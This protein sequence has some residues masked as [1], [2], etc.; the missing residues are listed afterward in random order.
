MGKNSFNNVIINGMILAEDGKKMA[1]KLKNY[2]DPEYLF[3]KYGSDAYRLYML[4]SPGVRAEPVKFSE[5][6]VDQIY[7]DFTAAIINAYKFFETYAK[8]DNFSYSKPTVYFMRHGE[9]E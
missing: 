4:S 9:S 8:V 1:K 2:P 6:G 3:N 5:K 7:K